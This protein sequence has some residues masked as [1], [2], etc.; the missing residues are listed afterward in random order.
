MLLA[1]MPARAADTV[2]AS[3]QNGYSRLSFSFAPTGHVTAASDGS[4]LTLSFDRKTTLDAGAMAR[5]M[6]GAVVSSP[7]R[8]RRQDLSLRPQPAAQAASEQRRRPRGGGPGAAEFRRR[9][10]RPAAAAPDGGAADRCRHPA[11]AGPAHRQLFQLTRLVFDWPR[12]VPYTVFPGAGKMTIKFQAAARP[13]LSAIA[14]FAPP[15]VKS[16]GWH[17]EGSDTVVEFQTDADSGYHDFTDGTHVVLDILAPKTGSYIPVRHRQAAGGGRQARR[18][19]AQVAAIADTARQLRPAEKADG[20]PAPLFAATP[21]RAD[22]QAGRENRRRQKA[23]AGAAGHAARLPHPPPRRARMPRHR[24]P[25]PRSRR[26]A[27]T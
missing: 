22:A 20:K 8:S 3:N 15:W 1:A 9:H 6:G 25:K 13:D 11:R 19:Q 5:L 23:R 24:R 26:R 4:V 21:P 18:E 7:R 27:R 10:A 16:A 2:S 17:L 14:R 12:T